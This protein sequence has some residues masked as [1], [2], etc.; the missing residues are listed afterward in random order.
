MLALIVIA[1]VSCQPFSNAGPRRFGS[2]ERAW[3][4][5]PVCDAAETLEAVFIILENV[6]N[7][8]DMDHTHGVW[9]KILSYYRSKGYVLVRV[10]RPRHQHCGGHTYRARVIPIFIK[11][12]MQHMLDL[13]PIHKLSFSEP[14]PLKSLDLDL[15][16]TRNWQDY[17]LFDRQR[18]KLRFNK[19]LLMPAAI[20]MIPGSRREWRVQ[21]VKG[22]KVYLQVTDRRSSQRITIDRSSVTVVDSDEA[23]HDVFLPSQTATNIR[24][25]GEPPGRGAPLIYDGTGIW[26]CELRARGAYNDFGKPEVDQML[27]HL[28][29]EQASSAIGNCLPKRMFLPVAQALSTVLQRFLTSG[30]QGHPAAPAGSWALALSHHTSG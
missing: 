15:D 22:E 26:S 9:S 19:N 25:S 18:M 17:G 6:C 30:V 23:E 12:S 28:T 5:I 21:K 4:A 14:T 7:Y 2:D 1:G 8:I 24:A 13:L 11:E 16:R 29:S 20:V 27:Q 3:D 10:L